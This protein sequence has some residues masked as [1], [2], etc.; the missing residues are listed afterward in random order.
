MTRVQGDAEAKKQGFEVQAVDE[1]ALV[2]RGKVFGLADQMLHADYEN[3]KLVYIRV[4]LF[5]KTIV[6]T[7]LSDRVLEEKGN[8]LLAAFG[9]KY[10]AYTS[11][12]NEASG[13]TTHTW[14]L[15]DKSTVLL[16]IGADD[17]RSI[18]M[19]YSK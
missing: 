13:S 12:F 14:V 2:Y 8:G 4:H 7:G 11:K 5:G 17:Y 15:S 1:Y 18:E 16:V 3:G 10:G 9:K 6:P 19:G